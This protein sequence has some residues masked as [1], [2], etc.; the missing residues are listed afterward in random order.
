MRF[1]A[2]L[3]LVLFAFVAACAQA[4]APGGAPPG[5]TSAPTP[6]RP[7][8]ATALPSTIAC[9]S[10]RQPRPTPQGTPPYLRPADLIDGPVAASVLLVMYG[11][12]QDAN[13]ALMNAGLVRLR[14][15]YP[16]D[17]ARIFRPYP[18][19]QHDKALL[20]TQAAAAAARQG[21]FWPF[22]DHLFAQQA[23]WRDL[24]PAA[25]RTYLL[26][27]AADLD[28]DAQRLAHDLDDPTLQSQAVAAR[29][30]AQRMGLPGVPLLYLNGRYYPGPWD[31]ASLSALV[32]LERLSTR[33]FTQCPPLLAPEAVPRF[34]TLHTKAG[35]LVI[36]LFP[37]RAPMAVSSF[38]FLA[39]H[40]WYANNT[41]FRV[42]PG[43][44]AQTGD[45]SETGLGHPGYTFVREIAP[46][47]SFDRPGRVALVSDGPQ[48][49]GSQ[50]LVTLA[51]APQFDG[52]YTLFGQV[53]QGLEILLALPARDPQEESRTPGLVITSVEVTGP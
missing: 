37:D 6:T 9:T 30:R 27:L 34:A 21:A 25:F 12:Y 39:R 24:D 45:P 49:N 4:P 14:Q 5:P 40:G 51:A 33:Q 43:L 11:D 32:R 10:V 20:A 48:S 22:H 46:D 44:L 41:F 28:L 8:R 52:Q 35:D 13:S 7:L 23:Q 36:Q 47:L 3:L 2:W 31:E 26:Q 1:Y 38:A 16:Q 29:Q 15:A 18:L 42:V 50:F 53:V 19:P 17:V